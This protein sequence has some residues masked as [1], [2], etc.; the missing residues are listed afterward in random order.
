MSLPEARNSLAQIAPY[1]QGKSKSAGGVAPVKLSSNESAYGASPAALAAYDSLGEQLHRYPDGEQADL[2]DA[3]AEVHGL[4]IEQIVCGNGSEELIGLVVRCYVREGDEVVLTRNH[5]VMSRIYSVA[6]GADLVYAEE[7]NDVACVDN[8]LNVVTPRTRMVIL[9]NPNNPTGTYVPSNEIDRLVEALPANVILILD[10]AYAEYAN[11]HDYSDGSELALNRGNVVVTH[12]FSK[13]YGL[14]GLRIGWALAAP[15]VIETINRIRTPFNTNSPALAAAAAAMRDQ[16]F[17]RMVRGNNV[18]ALEAILPE[19]RKMDF[20]VTDSVANF[21]LVD[22]ST[23]DGGDANTAISFMESKGIIV[24]PSGADER[25]RIT[26]GTD[27]ENTAVL[28]ALRE[29]RE[30]LA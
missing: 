22:V 16:Q 18:R 27:E 26:V 3:I 12:T 9:S 14:A 30:L 1:Q 8:I 29:Y 23:V 6:Q 13:I 20:S 4:P 5:F 17:V 24:R 7:A 15:D 11:V 10:G 25:V 28:L 2:R 21:Y 19:I